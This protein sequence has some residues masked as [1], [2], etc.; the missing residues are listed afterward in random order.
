[1]ATLIAFHLYQCVINQGVSYLPF[2]PL[3][4][5]GRLG[6]STRG[7]ASQDDLGI[8]G[9]SCWR[10]EPRA[11]WHGGQGLCSF[12]V[13]FGSKGGK[14][15]NKKTISF[16]LTNNQETNGTTYSGVGRGIKHTAAQRAD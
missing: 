4:F 1:M 14:R 16:P 12:D 15:L 3:V 11:W 6:M 9:M 10:H 5:P 8:S 2:G 7:T 13:G